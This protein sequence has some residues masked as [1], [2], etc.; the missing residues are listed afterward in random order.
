MKNA[1][2]QTQDC[3]AARILHQTRERQQSSPSSCFP[4]FPK[5]HCFE[6][7]YKTHSA[8]LSW[9][10]FLLSKSKWAHSFIK[11]YILFL[12]SN[13]WF[14]FYVLL[15]I[16]YALFELQV[17]VFWFCLY[18]TQCPRAVFWNCGRQWW[19]DCSEKKKTGEEERGE[20]STERI[21]V[22]AEWKIKCKTQQGSLHT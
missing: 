17:T 7:R 18:F 3:W 11:C 20:F 1:I 10:M 16:K 2:K 15:L 19:A 14:V 9:D 12:I 6:Q 4:L 22:L 13:I 5:L 8:Q 21:I